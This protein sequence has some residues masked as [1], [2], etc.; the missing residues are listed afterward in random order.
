MPVDQLGTMEP[1]QLLQLLVGVVGCAVTMLVLT[2]VY[3]FLARRSGRAAGAKA[4]MEVLPAIAEVTVDSS[5][6]GEGRSAVVAATPVALDVGARL[7]G[8]GRDA[9]QSSEVAPEEAV[10]AVDQ[11]HEILRVVQDP[12]SPT[13]NAWIKIGGVRYARLSEVRDR[14]VGERILAAISWAL[15]FSNG[16]VASDQGVVTLELP[17][18]DAVPVPTAIGVLVEEQEPGELFRLLGDARRNEF[19]VQVAGRRYRT[20]SEI[21]DRA[22]GQTVLNGISRLLQFSQGRIYANDGVRVLPVPRLSP[23]S[24]VAAAPSPPRAMPDEEEAFLEQM[25]R[26]LAETATQGGRRKKKGRGISDSKAATGEAG[27][28]FSL[29]D[30]IDA[31]LQRKLKDSSLARTDARF[32][33][34]L[35][36][37]VRIRVGGQYYDRPDQVPDAELRRIIEAA[38]AEW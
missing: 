15:R 23:V 2:V 29:V 11:H 32:V 28:S 22:I 27:S 33:A 18:C 7:A 5:A 34:G 16:R 30:E 38:I 19:W 24:T 13:G 26:Q 1:D 25:R 3:V 36:G 37:S 4:E 21:T 9:W 17:P 35:D 12:T 20:L 31:I 14:T 10:A 6:G 8:T